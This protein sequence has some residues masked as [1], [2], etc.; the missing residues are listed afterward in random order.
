M[1]RSTYSR[2]DGT[3]ELP[4]LDAD[5]LL[6]AMGDELIEHGDP[7]SALRRMLHQG[8]DVDG[9][10]LQGIREILERL[11]RARQERLGRDDLGGVYAEIDQALRDVIDEERAALG[12]P[13][14]DDMGGRDP[15][16]SSM[17]E[18][19][20]ASQAR[21]DHLDLIEHE[22]LAGKVRGLK[23]HAFASTEAR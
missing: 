8:L 10:H 19:S 15:E 18:A 14:T 9:Q 13:E 6:Q 2:W 23:Q 11:R 4:D 21:R 5:A 7:E 20:A 17:D 12:T 16:S 3:Q 1:R 22:N